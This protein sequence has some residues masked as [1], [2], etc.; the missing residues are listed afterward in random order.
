MDNILTRSE[1][2]FFYRQFSNEFTNRNSGRFIIVPRQEVGKL[3]NT[4]AAFQLSDFSSRAKTAEMERVLNGTQ[5]LSGVIGKVGSRITIS[6]SLYTYPELSQLPG[7]VDLR[8][9]NKDEL[10]DKIP[11]LVQ[12][13]QNAITGR[14]DG[15]SSLANMV[16]IE[17]GTFMMG[18]PTGES[19]RNNDETQHTVTLS[20]FY[21]SKYPVTQEEYYKIMGKEPFR[22]PANEHAVHVS[23]YDAVEYCNRRSQQDG[24]VPVYTINK[25]RSDSN[26]KSISDNVRWLVTWNREANGYR[27]PTEAEWEYACRAGTTTRYNT[28]DSISTYTANFGDDDSGTSVLSNTDNGKKI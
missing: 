13:M 3:I 5:I 7:G 1:S 6:I 17:S 27:L 11:E 16:R 26:N 12:G 4:E 10:F 19:G 23:W 15:E 2:I 24:L 18:S 22:Y 25:E 28:G 21:M 8:V 14:S 20:A 9:T